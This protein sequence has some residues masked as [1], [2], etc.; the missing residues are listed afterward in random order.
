MG[1]IWLQSVGCAKVAKYW[2]LLG[3]NLCQNI[4]IKW[5]PGRKKLHGQHS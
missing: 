1:N 2:S 3:A 4:I 5:I